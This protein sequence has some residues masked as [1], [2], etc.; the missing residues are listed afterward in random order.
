MLNLIEIPGPFNARIKNFMRS[1]YGQYDWRLKAWI[2]IEPEAEKA[3]KA[4]AAYEN[5]PPMVEMKLWL[6]K[7]YKD[8]RKILAIL[9]AAFHPERRVWLIPPDQLDYAQKVQALI[10]SDK[11]KSRDDARI[12]RNERL[13]EKYGEKIA[14]MTPEE[15]EAFHKERSEY[16]KNTASYAKSRNERIIATAKRRLEHNP[17]RE[18]RKK[19]GQ[20]KRLEAFRATTAKRK[21]LTAPIRDEIKELT[22]EQRLLDLKRSSHAKRLSAV[23]ATGSTDVAFEMIQEQIERDERA[24]AIDV[25]LDILKK[26]LKDAHVAV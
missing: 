19:A 1:C 7:K 22:A 13:K 6:G 10:D 9:G 21:E 20:A 25:R 18:A 2:V 3:K 8:E 12:R 5:D 15:L 26:R 4:V 17:D 14:A 16:Q 11:A 24:Q 23:M